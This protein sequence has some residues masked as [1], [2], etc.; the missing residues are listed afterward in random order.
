MTERARGRFLF[1]GAVKITVE[2]PTQEVVNAILLEI[3][4]ALF[5]RD[6]RNVTPEPR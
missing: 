4:V 5:H 6:T 2:A 1:P 3:Q